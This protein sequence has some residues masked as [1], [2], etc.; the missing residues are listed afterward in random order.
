MFTDFRK[1]ILF[2]LSYYNIFCQNFLIFLILISKYFTLQF[3]DL[4]DQIHGEES[5]KFSNTLGETITVEV[6]E[7]EAAT[8]ELLCKVLN[9]DRNAADLLAAEVHKDIAVDD[10]NSQISGYLDLN[11]PVKNLSIWIDPIGYFFIIIPY[12]IFFLSNI[13]KS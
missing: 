10:I 9:G 3:P 4:I 1:L 2:V 7:T 5:N 6:Q 11:I 12:T 8:S 13:H